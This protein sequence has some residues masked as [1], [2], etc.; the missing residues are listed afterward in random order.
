MR[1]TRLRF[2]AALALLG[3]ASAVKASTPSSPLFLSMNCENGY[4]EAVASGG[5]GVYSFSWTN[6]WE[7]SE[8]MFLSSAEPACYTSGTITVSVRVTDSNGARAT[9]SR[10]YS[11]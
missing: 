8:D 9:V 3:T 6:A 1:A 2:I 4:C 7:I 10:P 11:C 5:S